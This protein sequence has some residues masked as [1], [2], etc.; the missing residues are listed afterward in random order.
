[1]TIYYITETNWNNFLHS[2]IRQYT[3]YGLINENENL[4]WHRIKT[5]KANE[6]TVT[7]YRSLQPIKT[8]FY[9]IK[10][11]VTQEPLEHKTVII[12]AKACDLNHLKTTD[13]IFLGGVIE[14][15]YYA[16][17]RKTTIIIS[18]DCSEIK[19]SCFC[20]L[21]NEHPYPDKGYDLNLIDT[22][23]GFLVETGTTAGELLISSNKH[24]FQIPQAVLLKEKENQ[25]NKMIEI[26]KNNNQNFTWKNPEKIVSDG[27][28]SNLWEKDI[29]ETCVEC[30]AC[31]FTCSTC[32]CF[33][34]S[35]TKQ[36]WNKIRS[37]DSC[38]ST[39]YARVAGGANPR[40][41][42]H[43][44]LRN[45]YACKMLYRHENFGF[46]ACTGCGRCI[47]VCQG[48]ID[49]RQ[50]LQKLYDQMHK[51]KVEHND[52]KPL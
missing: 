42:R 13:S 3:V 45:L 6:L 33:F 12:G 21:M 32:Y 37:W 51:N 1:M 7:R 40:K 23:A 5:E 10:E 36:L 27:F 18:A 25:R 35:E 43:S 2:L 44:R 30:D 11:E 52:K 22:R 46:Y 9:P 29:A 34:L 31:R 48:K 17:K 16:V 41:T 4:F 26:V 28:S 38:Q 24:Y 50:S 8:Y 15:P 19:Q 14:D 20:T 47:D 49:I 39:G